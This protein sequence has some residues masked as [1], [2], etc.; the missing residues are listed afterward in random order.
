LSC[1]FRKLPVCTN[2]GTNHHWSV[3]TFKGTDI[4]PLAGTAIHITADVGDLWSR[5]L[6]FV[7]AEVA[8][9]Y[10]RII[11]HHLTRAIENENRIP[12]QGLMCFQIGNRDAHSFFPC[13]RDKGRKKLALAV[14]GGGYP[15]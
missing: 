8:D 6:Q 9:K 3:R 10:F 15:T 13:Q 2:H 5:L 14:Y 4:K 11:E 7:F 1:G 12:R